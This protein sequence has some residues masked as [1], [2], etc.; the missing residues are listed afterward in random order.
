MD[1]DDDNGSEAG[2]N[3]GGFPPGSLFEGSDPA[4]EFETLKATL[5]PLRGGSTALVKAALTSLEAAAV[6]VPGA[7][8]G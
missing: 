1:D 8:A 3:A 7:A 4:A 2:V 5:R 6:V